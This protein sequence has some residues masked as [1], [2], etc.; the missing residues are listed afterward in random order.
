MLLAISSKE[1]IF[2]KSF[3][4]NLKSHLSQEIYTE[5]TIKNSQIITAI[6][7]ICWKRFT[8]YNIVWNLSIEKIKKICP[9]NQ[10][11]LIKSKSVNA[12]P[13]TEFLTSGKYRKIA[14]L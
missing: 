14:E 13:Y 1:H 9:K 2:E 12:K 7:I 3:S 11:I 4:I 8:Q 10:E 6:V 5:K